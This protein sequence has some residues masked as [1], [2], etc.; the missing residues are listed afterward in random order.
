MGENRGPPGL[1]LALQYL[2]SLD[3]PSASP[4]HN[5][6]SWSGKEIKNLRPL[7]KE[8]SS[9]L[10]TVQ[11]NP[12][13]M[14]EQSLDSTGGRAPSSDSPTSANTGEGAMGEVRELERAQHHPEI[15]PFPNQHPG[16]PMGM[17]ASPGGTQDTEAHH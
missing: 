6:V 15:P 2:Q 1:V 17:G 4:G 16:E 11:S 8:V 3:S 10:S 5:Q 9:L 14:P 13:K 7:I 12:A